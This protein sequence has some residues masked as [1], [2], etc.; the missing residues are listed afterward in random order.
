M[1]FLRGN[2]A[3]ELHLDSVSPAT[4]SPKNPSLISLAT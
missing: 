2:L 4:K 3:L 1:A